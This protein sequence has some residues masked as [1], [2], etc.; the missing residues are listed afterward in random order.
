MGAPL[1]R[2]RA[3]ANAVA[4]VYA[5]AM[6]ASVMDTQIVNV[7]LTSLSRDFHVTDSSVQWV[8][9][10]YMMSL[11]V[12]VPA[13]GWL[14]D[15]FGTKRVFLIAVGVF[16]AAS[17]LCAASV[18]LPELVAMR[19]LQGAGAGMM[20]PVGMAIVYRAYPQERR[21]HA[22]RL[23][24]RVM[25]LAPATAPLIGGA[26]VT[27]ASWRWIFTINLPVGAVVVVGGVLLLA[28]HREPPGG[29]FDLVGTV[30][31][32]LGVGLLLY[33]VGSGPTAGWGS[34]EVL[35]A[36][37]GALVFLALFVRVE[38]RRAHPLL[39]LRLL[40][41]RL[42]RWCGI[43]NMLA[44]WAFFGS[45]VFT[46]FY[47]QEARG[48]SAMASG[49]TT[50]PEAVAIGI[51][52]GLV[53]RLFPRVGP[54]RLLLTGFGGL[55]VANGLF[56]M[57]GASTS[58][59]LV[60]GL[61]AL[62]GCSVSFI[63]LSSQTAAFAQISTSATGHASAIFNTFQRVSMSMGVAT[64]TAVLALAGGDVVHARPPVTAFHWVFATN[65]VVALLGAA[66]SSRV[67]DRD[68][69]PAMRKVE[70]P[71]GGKRL[72]AQGTPTP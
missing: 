49:L 2:L 52:T 12:C 8:V 20:V 15:R 40:G 5:V 67:P 33:A 27:W 64:L 35:S 34:T 7:A 42:F 17:G 30:S 68:A 36:G 19:V 70:A 66:I 39:D 61:C 56:A 26:L 38:L 60:R 24:T 62:L 25:V 29:S 18:N 46:A 72:R 48:D 44:M 28:E 3:H 22:T 10:A 9:T 4:V 47:V 21:V 71:T 58:L 69:A 32:V 53:A 14:G 23:V 13:S 31:G 6:F 16:T 41:N 63:M 1:D 45:L 55:A 11:A 57:V 50:F 37:L 51:M 59:W 54:R 65:V 43:A